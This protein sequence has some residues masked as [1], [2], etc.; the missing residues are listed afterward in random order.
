MNVLFTLHKKTLLKT[1]NYSFALKYIVLDKFQVKIR[2]SIKVILSI[3]L[4]ILSNLQ[5]L[6]NAVICICMLHLIQIRII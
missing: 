5:L 2:F 1:W 6:K 4:I 3:Y